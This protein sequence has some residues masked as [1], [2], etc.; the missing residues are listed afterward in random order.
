MEVEVRQSIEHVISTRVAEGAPVDIRATVAPGGAA[1]ALVEASAGA[2]LVVVGN[3]GR[4]AV[5][6]ALLGSVAQQVAHHAHCPVVLVPRRPAQ[7][8]GSA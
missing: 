3:H 2:V 1:A 7:P 6:G 4:N 5:S 8:T